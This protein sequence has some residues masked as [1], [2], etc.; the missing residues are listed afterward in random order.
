LGVRLDVDV[1]WDEIAAIVEDAY[2]QVAPRR[3][4]AELDE[5]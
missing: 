5:G 2:R 1:D 4:V 3:L